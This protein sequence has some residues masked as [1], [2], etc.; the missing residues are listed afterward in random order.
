MFAVESTTR[1]V[2]Y[3]V[4]EC[5]VIGNRDGVIAAF[6]LFKPKSSVAADNWLVGYT[7]TGSCVDHVHPIFIGEVMV[8]SKCSCVD[9]TAS[10]KNCVKSRSTTATVDG[11]TG[12]DFGEICV[13]ECL[14]S[15]IKQ[16][17]WNLNK[18]LTQTAD[19]V[20]RYFFRREYDPRW[21]IR[22]VFI[23]Q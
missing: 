3:I 6:V 16:S 22:L 12:A 4:V 18:L 5:A 20:V 2:N 7:R 23:R 17:R 19:R 15:W 11:N 8:Y 21:Y 14:S 1:F 9:D 13:D 10:G